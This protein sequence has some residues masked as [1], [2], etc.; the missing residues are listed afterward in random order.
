MLEAVA[1][2]DRLAVPDRRRGRR[3]L[4]RSGVRRPGG[5]PRA[6]GRRG[7]QPA[8][9]PGRISLVR[10]AT[11]PPSRSA[12]GA[13]PVGAPGSGWTSAP[14]AAP[15]FHR[16]HS[17][18]LVTDLR[19]AQLPAGMLD[20]LADVALAAGRAAARRARR[21]RCAPRRAVRSAHRQAH[22]ATQ[23][24]EGGYEA[25]SGSATRTGRCRSP[26]SGR[27]TAT[28]RGSTASWWRDWAQPGRGHDRVG[29]LRRRRRFRRG[30]GRG[31]GE[32]GHV[33]SVDTLARRRRGRRGPRWPICRRCRWSPTRCVGR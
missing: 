20:G 8:A 13:R 1:R 12:A 26:R 27:R 18:E 11:R 30:A 32:T 5:G 17:D 15:G 16:Y 31:G 21:R 19:C 28:R 3:R 25:C 4:L 2:P 9:T 24:V 14:T 10:R 33:V 6:Q 7:G 23:V 22:G 29:P